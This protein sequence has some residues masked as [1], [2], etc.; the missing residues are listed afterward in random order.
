MCLLFCI[1]K[2]FPFKL[3]MVLCGVGVDHDQLEKLAEK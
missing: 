1:L 3:R 2:L